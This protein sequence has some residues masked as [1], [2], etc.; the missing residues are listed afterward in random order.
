MY[1]AY[2]A[3]QK[4]L[5]FNKN[6]EIECKLLKFI[7]HYK[8]ISRMINLEYIDLIRQIVRMLRLFLK[9]LKLQLMFCELI[10][11]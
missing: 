2:G 8:K 3:R 9:S 1:L 5:C 11:S 10:L 4:N 6:V 7:L